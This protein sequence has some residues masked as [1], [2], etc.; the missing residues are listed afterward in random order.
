MVAVL[1]LFLS[2]GVDHLLKQILPA[3]SPRRLLR[4]HL[5]R[6][7]RF[8]PSDLLHQTGGVEASLL[9]HIR[10]LLLV[11]PIERGDVAPVSRYLR[12]RVRASREERDRV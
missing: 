4:G 9:G 2:R 12:M 8:E 3:R 11:A 1:E 5:A 6:A 10:R 7:D